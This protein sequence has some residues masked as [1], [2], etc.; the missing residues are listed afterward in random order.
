MTLNEK[1]AL[2]LYLE[3]RL[4]D[5]CE[6]MEQHLHNG[7]IGSIYDGMYYILS[8]MEQT[9]EVQ[10]ELSAAYNKKST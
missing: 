8:D 2:L 9:L 4:F 3:H 5:Y 6:E 7:D 10:V 1:E